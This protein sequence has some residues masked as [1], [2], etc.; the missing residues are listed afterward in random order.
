MQAGI[1]VE[2]TIRQ[3]LSLKLKRRLLG[4]NECE[5]RI[6]VSRLKRGPDFRQATERLAAAGWPTK[7]ARLHADVLT[8][9]PQSAIRNS[10]SKF[11]LVATATAAAATMSL[12]S[13]RTRSRRTAATRGRESGKLSRKFLRAAVRAFCAFPIRRSD[14]DFALFPAFLAI[15]FVYWHDRSLFEKPIISRRRNHHLPPRTGRCTFYLCRF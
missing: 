5:R 15:K 1:A 6:V 13:A 3:Q 11:P 2:R 14:K 12:V 10:Q 4:R 7:K 9:I 8:K